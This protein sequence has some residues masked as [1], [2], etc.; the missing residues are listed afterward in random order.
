MNARKKLV[1]IL[2]AALVVLGFVIFKIFGGDMRAR[3]AIDRFVL[4]VEQDRLDD[5]R[6]LIYF[7]SPFV[8]TSRPIDIEALINWHYSTRVVVESDELRQHAH[9]L[10]QLNSSTLIPDTR[11]SEMDLRIY[12]VFETTNGRRLFDAAISM[13]RAD[14]TMS[15]NG[16]DFKRSDMFID[17][18]MP[19]LPDA[20]AN[21]LRI[22]LDNDGVWPY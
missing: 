15:I 2:F 21:S 1:L 12:F 17:I 18:I 20:A 11:G 5:V 4:R 19:F 10:R 22:F 14:G 9:I 6:L 16:R 13:W 7:M 3:S 8:N